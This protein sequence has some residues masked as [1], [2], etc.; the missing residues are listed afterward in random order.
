MKGAINYLQAISNI[1]KANKGDCK[2]CELGNKERLEDNFCPRLIHPC[3]WDDERIV[4]MV[5][6]AN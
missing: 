5:R 3:N 4:E 1:C 2:K 6:R